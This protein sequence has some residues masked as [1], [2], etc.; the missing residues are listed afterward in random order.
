MLKQIASGLFKNALRQRNSINIMNCRFE[1]SL[2]TP[3]S[4][5][6]KFTTSEAHID[7]K[8]TRNFYHDDQSLPRSH[9]MVLASSLIFGFF[10]LIF[11]RDDIEND[12]GVNLFKPIHEQI[13]EYAI[14]MLQAAI[15]ENRKLGYNTKKLE[16]KLAEYMK[17]P[18]KYGGDSKKLI[19]N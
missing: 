19:E 1:S 9:N 6:V 13:P 14:P 15:V 2:D 16:M 17:E 4:G 10:Y 12:G 8:A 7:Y 18:E 5:P 3:K 11:L